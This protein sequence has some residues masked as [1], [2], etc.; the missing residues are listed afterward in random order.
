MNLHVMYEETIMKQRIEML[1]KEIT[2]AVPSID[3]NRAVIYTKMHMMYPDRPLV[4]RNALALEELFASVPITIRA[5]ELVVGAPTAV[6]R[7]CQV[8]PEVQSGWLGAELDH[9]PTREWDP[10]QLK[11]EDKKTL[12]EFVLPFWKGKTINERVYSQ[13]DIKTREFLYKDPNVYPT[14]PSCYI[15]NFSLLEKGIG[16]VVP[17][18]EKIL[19]NGALSVIEEI[20]MAASNLD[21][22]NPQDIDKKIF[23]DA[24]RISINGLIKF[25]NRYSALAAEMAKNEKD[26][27]RKEELLTISQICAR[28]PAEKPSNFYEAIQAFWFIHV[29]VRMEMSGH[30]LS[31]GRFDQYMFK[32]YK[33]DNSKDD[34]SKREHALE[35]IECLF[36]K[37]SE[38]MLLVSTTTSMLYAGVPQWQNLNLGGKQIDGCDATNDLSYICLQAMKELLL[39]QPD[40]SVRIH[41][42]T[43]EPFLLEACRLARL[44]TG[45]PKFY[46]DELITLSLASKGLSLEEARDYSIMGCV[47][48]RVR[49][50]G[51]HLTGGFLNM[52]LAVVLALH[53]G[54]VPDCNKRLGPQTGELA[55]FDSYDKFENAV[56]V[57][58]E[59]MVKHLFIVNAFAE[60]AY[61]EIIS[62][63]FLSA[64]TPGCIESGRTLQQGGA[65]YNFGPAVNM[66]G[67]TDAG[68]SMYSIK[69]MVFEE[70][71]L[72]LEELCAALDNNF[73][74]NKKLQAY[75]KNRIPKYGNDNDEADA[76]VC[77]I[78]H[79]GNDAVMKYK[80]IFGGQA[81][82]G[83]I[84][85]TSGIAFGKVIGALPSGRM[86]GEAYADSAS[87]MP[88]MDINGPT[89]MLC[90]VG[91]MDAAKLRNGTLLN[92]KINPNLV[93]SDEGLRNFAA[94]IR[95]GF[96]VGVWH[97]QINCVSSETLRAAQ[98]RPQD[99]KN[100]LVRVAGYSAYFASL[101]KEVQE[102]IIKRTEFCEL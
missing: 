64:L 16:T 39:V 35:L 84:P 86:S 48:P 87:P 33:N 7:A 80:N 91:K 13:L 22:T 32:F 77:R 40:I 67:V 75:L 94:M 62:T 89:A 1:K 10:L 30:S 29:A 101:H 59:N 11:E 93:S 51:I 53:N 43:P 25:A 97:M 65:L 96:S 8:F 58:L 18:Y 28:V 27:Q 36:L 37:F 82:A 41:S 6:P 95:G 4:L 52:P 46:N 90:S 74:N 49:G 70:K 102:D 24:A 5:N 66:I 38:L 15:D 61:T 69:K 47:E 34:S 12:E 78:V 20:N 73:L 60:K 57:Q 76:C 31:P 42:K 2:D 85:V 92:V 50:E 14:K 21:L 26:L 71:N 17:N 68:D 72:T 54:N 88:G 100:L 79:M 9:L 44:G 23:Y 45:H 56:R 81:D 19:A 55:S 99:Y 63:P 83:I 3:I 98:K